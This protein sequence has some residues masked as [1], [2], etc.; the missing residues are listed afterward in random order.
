MTGIFN[1]E[2]NIENKSL[3]VVWDQPATMNQILDKLKEVNYLA[4]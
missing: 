4:E 2:G 1:V 3:T